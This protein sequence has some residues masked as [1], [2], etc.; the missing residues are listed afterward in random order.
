MVDGR[1]YAIGFAFLMIFGGSV[2]LNPGS[3]VT[4]HIYAMW[5]FF[6]VRSLFQVLSPQRGSPHLLLLVGL[7]L[8]SPVCGGRLLQ[9][10]AEA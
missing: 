6:E 7:W 10:Q 5:S 8:F 9:P 4:A 2:N 1:L 3:T